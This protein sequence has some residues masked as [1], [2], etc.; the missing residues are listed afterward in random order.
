MGTVALNTFFGEDWM[1]FF[2]C[3]TS[4]IELYLSGKLLCF[5][6]N[7]LSHSFIF[8]R[9]QTAPF[10]TYFSILFHTIELFP[11][12]TQIFISITLKYK[13]N[14]TSSSAEAIT[15]TLRLTTRRYSEKKKYFM[16]R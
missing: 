6:K 16:R 2:R 11:I 7:T 3:E 4:V 14:L 9:V 12:M 1:I 15:L 5:L 13:F 8:L 10:Y